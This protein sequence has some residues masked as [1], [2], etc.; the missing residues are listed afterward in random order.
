MIKILLNKNLFR[1]QVKVSKKMKK[2]KMM[3]SKSIFHQNIKVIFFRGM[4]RNQFAHFW[5][6]IGEMM[7]N[8]F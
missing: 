4:T 8:I 2:I 7:E 6:L 3:Y 5:S 1:V